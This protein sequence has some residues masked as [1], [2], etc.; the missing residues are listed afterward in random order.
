MQGFDKGPETELS[1]FV[2]NALLA[3]CC[4]Q[5]L[6]LSKFLRL[7]LSRHSAAAPAAARAPAAGDVAEGEDGVEGL[8]GRQGEATER[9]Q[10]TEPGAR[11]L[12]GDRVRGQKG[13]GINTLEATLV[14]EV[15]FYVAPVVSARDNNNHKE[16]P[17]V[18]PVR[19]FIDAGWK[20]I[21]DIRKL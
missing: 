4:Q 21:K 19:H 15:K 13:D 17:E 16:E 11:D 9:R 7:Y 5:H 20:F 12:A 18:I 6:P 2:V 10:E 14:G 1:D 3:V 8:A